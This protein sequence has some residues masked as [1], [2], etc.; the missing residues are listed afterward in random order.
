MLAGAGVIFSCLVSGPRVA[1]VRKNIGLVCENYIKEAV[2]DTGSKLAGWSMQGPLTG[3]LFTFCWNEL[4]LGM[5]SLSRIS[6]AS[7]Y[8]GLIKCRK[9]IYD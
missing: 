2:G 8:Q 9:F 5:G 7:R 6:K 4:A 3:K 1:K